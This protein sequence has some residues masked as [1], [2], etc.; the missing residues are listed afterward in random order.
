MTP[1]PLKV[2]VATSRWAGMRSIRRQLVTFGIAGLSALLPAASSLV[3]SEGGPLARPAAVGIELPGHTRW[4]S[5]PGHTRWSSDPGHTRWSSGGST[6]PGATA[7][8]E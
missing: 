1:L 3:V 8:L 5:D 7:G 2:V 6:T 4:S